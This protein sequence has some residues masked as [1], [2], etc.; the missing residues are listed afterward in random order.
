MRY[1]VGVARSGAP[2]L[3]ALLFSSGCF[4]AWDERGGEG[5]SSSSGGASS[6]VGG[7]GP[8]TAA[9]GSTV[10]GG[11]GGSG[12]D[13]P[14]TT[15]ATSSASGTVACENPEACQVNTYCMHECGGVGTCEPRSTCSPVGEDPPPSPVC[16]C[17][18]R[19]LPS[20]CFAQR[21]PLAL[22][23]CPG[24]ITAPCGDVACSYDDDATRRFCLAS[25]QGSQKDLVFS[26][27]A[28]DFKGSCGRD[29]A[30]PAF[31]DPDCWHVESTN[32]ACFVHDGLAIVSCVD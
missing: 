22:G 17:E 31:C 6:S 21:W 5:A 25:L 32:C 8:S 23:P 13:S 12:A 2:W 26:C 4:Y 20:A 24:E 7:G 9:T 28:Y 19:Q 16:D 15:S 30:E 1:A 29:P 11:E 14:A 3:A 18:G 27:N 10:S